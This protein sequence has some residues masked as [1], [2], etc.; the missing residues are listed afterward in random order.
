M[1]SSVGVCLAPTIDVG[2]GVSC[3]VRTIAAK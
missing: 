2:L 3:Y 1:T